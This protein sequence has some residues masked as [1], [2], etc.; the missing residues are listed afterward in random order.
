MRSKKAESV[1]ESIHD[2]EPVH[3]NISNIDALKIIAEENTEYTL[4]EVN[5]RFFEITGKS[6]SKS[7]LKVLWYT[8][9][10]I[11]QVNFSKTVN[12]EEV[13]SST[14][15]DSNNQENEVM[16]EIKEEEVVVENKKEISLSEAIRKILSKKFDISIADLKKECEKIVGK[17]PS[18]PLIFQI[19]A[20]MKQGKKI[21]KTTRKVTE[22]RKKASVASKINIAQLTEKVKK[23]KSLIDEFEG[24][25]NLLQ[26][27]A[28]L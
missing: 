25:E 14:G 22:V 18:N 23:I 9:L 6:L 2:S 28:A 17:A 4:E 16:T 12:V 13:V 19:K 7:Q 8:V 26:F 10:G 11:K 24:K 1:S 21:E 15:L 5:D 20:K 27:V 3:D